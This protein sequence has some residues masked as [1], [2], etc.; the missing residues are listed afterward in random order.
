MD[1]IQ[2]NTEALLHVS[3]EVG[4]KMNLEKTNYMLMSCYQKAGKKV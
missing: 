3:K 4:L 1:M 2:K